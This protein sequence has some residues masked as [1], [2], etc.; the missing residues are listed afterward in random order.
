MPEGNAL[1][2]VFSA[3][4]NV[5]SYSNPTVNALIAGGG[6]TG[7]NAMTQG[8]SNMLGVAQQAQQLQSGKVS[9]DT[10]TYN[11]A[12]AK[13]NGLSE[14]YRSIMDNPTSDNATWQLG[15]AVQAGTVD[16][17]A[18]S[19]AAAKLASFGGDPAKIKQFALDGA[20]INQSHQEAL[21]QAYGAPNL[22]NVGGSLVS[23]LTRTGANAGTTLSGAPALPVT[24]SPGEK[25]AA[26]RTVTDGNGGQTFVPGSNLYDDRGN[27]IGGNGAGA[28]GGSGGGSDYYA[29][30]L[31]TGGG[32]SAPP[33]LVGGNKAP[34]SPSQSGSSAGQPSP[35]AAQPISFNG[36]PP[37]G[38][39]LS[40]AAPAQ[41]AAASSP[42]PA[43]AGAGDPTSAG[44]TWTPGPQ[45]MPVVTLE[46][47]QA[48]A[49]R[50][51]T[52]QGTAA[53]RN[54]LRGYAVQN[55]IPLQGKAAST[56]EAQPGQAPQVAAPGGA[57]GAP[58]PAPTGNPVQPGQ[59][60]TPLQ[61]PGAGQGG[62]VPASGLGRG[63]MTSSLSPGQQASLTAGANGYA[64]L[65]GDVSAPTGV[66]QRVFQLRT[67][68][69]ALRNTQT[70]LGT[71]QR[72]QLVGY[73]ASL[74]G[75]LD[76]WAP[77]LDPD[78]ATSYDV[79]TKYLNAYA[80]NTPGAAR[81][82]AGLSTAQSANANTSGMMQ[83]A[84]QDV[85]ISNIGLELGKRAMVNAFD[86]NGADP[87]TFNKFAT[88]WSQGVDPR[89]F[90]L[91]DM[92]PAER[93]TLF[94]S[95]QGQQR[96][97]FLATIRKGIA[98]NVISKTD[99]QGATGGQ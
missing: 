66:N 34:S 50:A 35:T 33:P 49:E 55:N 27:Y 21:D 41:P 10:Q 46:Q 51:K 72:Q 79:A 38:G 39:G 18:A 67:A 36:A 40:G 63:G 20:N 42:P 23:T 16:P 71:A 93:S 43:T 78:S 99:L 22:T 65:S 15:Q 17:T 58:A 2:G 81:S 61:A 85:T 57:P 96:T 82:D 47:A 91:G 68:L 1:A 4:P 9:I 53:D 26:G 8:A 70:G 45:T 62:Q 69:G 37:T 90:A 88:Q 98:A 48:A 14:I 56:W 60:P 83:K 24:A 87:G 28:G 6:Q 25:I 44:G 52:P 59:S 19:Q 76:K 30:L 54:L 31:R 97:N 5:S 92:T 11:L 95:L 12:K 13:M 7:S 64:A 77:G 29:N 89:A 74:P 3:Q 80:L 75:G 86:K 94:T 32:T 84:A 73:L